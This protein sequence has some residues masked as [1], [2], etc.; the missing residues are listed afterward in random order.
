MGTGEAVRGHGT[1]TE[2]AIETRGLEPVPE[3]ERHGPTWRIF[4]VWFSGNMVPPTF[5]IG[6]LAAADFIQ[7]GFW[8]GLAAILL[9]NVIGASFVGLAA[10]MGPR[11]GMPQLALGRLSFGRSNTVPALL[12][13]AC[14]IAWAAVNTFFGAAAFALVTGLPFWV[15]ALSSIA[16]M[17]IIVVI[18]YE[19]ILNFQK[20]VAGLLAVVFVLAAIRVVTVG[21]F[22]RGDGLTGADRTGAFV[23]MTTL[24]ASFSLSWAVFGSDYT[25]YLP[26]ETRD[27]KVFACASGGLAV[28]CAW[29]QI[30]GLA[31][32]GIITGSGVGTIRDEVLGGGFLGG[33][34]MVAIFLGIVSVTVLNTY[35]ASL[36]LLTVG[37]GVPRTV[38][39]V[40]AAVL[41]FALTLWL[42]STDFAGTFSNYLLIIS[43]WVAPY[44]AVVLVDWWMRGRRADVSGLTDTASLDN[45]WRAVLSFAVGVAASVPFMNTTLYVGPV[46]AGPLHGGD[47]AYYVGF[48]V[49]AAAYYILRKPSQKSA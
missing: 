44:I 45:G 30:L 46:A 24:V 12:N 8:S 29:L 49:A 32:A 19:A 2:L 6:T 4:T 37:I 39:A 35:T 27:W 34:A 28:A 3:A 7:L 36:S 1:P 21:D 38:S 16:L 10:M 22:T 18:G 41:A 15:G 26:R 11:T 48:V 31:V 20:Y 23:L 14:M 33:A 25:R 40:I 5:F 13:W 42:Q 47:I 17:A 43:Y 9:G